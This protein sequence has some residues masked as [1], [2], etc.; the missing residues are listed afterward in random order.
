MAK[1][2]ALFSKN[3]FKDRIFSIFFFVS[4]F[5]NILLWIFILW[6][7]KPGADPVYLHYNIY[8]GIDLIGSYFRLYFMPLSGLI[9]FL[10][11]AVIS[12]II[13]KQEKIISYFL[14]IISACTQVFLWVA[15]VLIVLINI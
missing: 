9:I 12:A 1:I 7:I 6:Q 5:L 3:L 2:T 15:T 14:I 4:I 11:N 10:L 13:Y 8:F